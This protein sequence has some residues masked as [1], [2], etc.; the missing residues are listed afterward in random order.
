MLDP[1]KIALVAVSRPGSNLALR[2]RRAMPEAELFL[3][4]RFAEEVNPSVHPWRGPLGNL[5]RQLFA[6]YRG[7]VLF[8]AVGMA[9]RLVAPLARD[10][11]TDPAVVVVDDAGR[12]AVSLLSGH[13]GGANALA[14]R[15]AKILGAQAVVTTASEVLDTLA[16]DLLGREFG[17]RLEKGEN[18]ARVTAALINREAVGLL[19]EAGEPDWWPRG[20]QFPTNLHRFSSPEELIAAHCHAALVITDRALSSWEQAL[21]PCVLCRPRS[22]VVGIGCHRGTSA[23][24]IAAAV[25]QAVEGHGLAL[26]SVRKLATVSFKRHEAGLEEFARKLAVPIEYYTPRQL[27]KVSRLPNPSGLV[28]DWV[29]TLGVCEPAALLAS[30]AEELVVPKLKTTKVT[31]AVARMDFSRVEAG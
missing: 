5:V 1:N 17:W 30:G 2:L 15:I 13:Q 20:K 9:V 12:F 8:G 10:K 27:D 14:Q 6:E 22:L 29:G 25:T 16:V 7:L 31:A 24:E 19:Q 23:E 26:A 3:P 21:P 28:R 4:E 11:H 18:V